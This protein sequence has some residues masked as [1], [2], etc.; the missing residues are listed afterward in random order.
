MA[1]RS[2]LRHQQRHLIAVSRVRDAIVRA[3]HRELS[4]AKR[5]ERSAQTALALE[6]ASSRD[7]LERWQS[8]IAS[9]RPDP[10][11]MQAAAAVVVTRDTLRQA[12]AVRCQYA[13]TKRVNAETTTIMR[14]AELAL[15]D[16]VVA[17]NRRK[18]A[19]VMEHSRSLEVEERALQR[20]KGWR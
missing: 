16:K 2:V 14:E 19:A 12:A 9:M 4:I 7:A 6:L 5:A 17:D 11:L 18:L 1:D 13:A 20:W 3:S 8:G 10:L 15:A